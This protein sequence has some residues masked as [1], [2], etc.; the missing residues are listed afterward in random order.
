MENEERRGIT[1]NK[2]INTI[3]ELF[4]TYRYC[5]IEVINKK[6]NS[7]F[8]DSLNDEELFPTVEVNLKFSETK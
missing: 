1:F 7:F 2:I 8:T 4:S 5:E 3:K 6:K